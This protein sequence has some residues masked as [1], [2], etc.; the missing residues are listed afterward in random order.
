[1]ELKSDMN[2]QIKSSHASTYDVIVIGA[3]MSGMYLIYRLRKLGFSV[4][5]F[6]TGSG[7]GGTWY[8]NR[9][10][11][12]RFDSESYSYGFSFSKELLDEWEWSEHFSSQPENL[13]YLEFVADKFD[14]RKD[15]R[16]DTRIKGAVYDE[17]ENRWEVETETGEK[18]CCR[19]LIT[20]IG[21]LSAPTMANDSRHRY[22]PRRG[23]SHGPLAP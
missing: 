9:Y 17:S 15:I 23:L 19:F 1:M 10:P 3:G 16:F 7:V 4:R 14:L 6:E 21:I 12:A 8:W 2:E 20:A 5:V 13:R 22:F 18:A 11:G